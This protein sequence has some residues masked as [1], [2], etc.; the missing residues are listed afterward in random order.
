MRHLPLA[1]YGN[2]THM[3]LTLPSGKVLQAWVHGR[4]A[5]DAHMNADY[6]QQSMKEPHRHIQSTD[7]LHG[8]LVLAA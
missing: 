2:S 5:V 6:L 8:M 1:I 7:I 4:V 3:L